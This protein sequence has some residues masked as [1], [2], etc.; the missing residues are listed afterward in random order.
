MELLLSDD[1]PCSIQ[2]SASDPAPTLVRRYNNI[3][4]LH[5]YIIISGK[6]VRMTE[7]LS[8]KSKVLIIAKVMLGKYGRR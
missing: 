8:P 3:V 2:R 6:V 7:Y 5:L 1:K 4:S